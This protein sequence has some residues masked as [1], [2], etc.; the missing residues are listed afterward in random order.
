MYL[1]ACLCTMLNCV[2]ITFS[3]MLFFL[4]QYGCFLVL[5]YLIYTVAVLLPRMSAS[6]D[7]KCSPSESE[8]FLT[9][10]CVPTYLAVRRPANTAQPEISHHKLESRL[11]WPWSLSNLDLMQMK[12]LYMILDTTVDTSALRRSQQLLWSR[13]RLM[14]NLLYHNKALCPHPYGK[15]WCQGSCQPT[16]KYS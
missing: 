13:H 4:P 12:E 5:A 9:T 1:K 11:S 15:N 3:A 7:S 14:H 8:S 10:D 16:A 2:G 6:S